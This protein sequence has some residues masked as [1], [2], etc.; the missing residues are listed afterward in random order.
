MIFNPTPCVKDCP[1]RS[2]ICHCGC[3][4]HAE[5]KAEENRMNAVINTVRAV[6]R[7]FIEPEVD[8]FVK[9]VIKQHGKILRGQKAW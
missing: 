4:R 5:W 9:H 6:E 7:G 1:D 2:A 3:I 8:S